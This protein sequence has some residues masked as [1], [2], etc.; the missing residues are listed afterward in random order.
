MVPGK[1]NKVW[2]INRRGIATM[3]RRLET[4]TGLPCSAHTFRKT[5][6]IPSAEDG[7]DSMTINDLGR[8]ESL[9]MDQRYT[10][11]MTFHDRRKFYKGP[12]G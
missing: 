8:W 12:L 2:G 4:E 10:M 5:F 9:E 3:L 6:A 1:G 7:V 11:A